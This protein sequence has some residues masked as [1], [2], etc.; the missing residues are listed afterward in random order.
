MGMPPRT[1]MVLRLANGWAVRLYQSSVTPDAPVGTIPLNDIYIAKNLKEVAN[2]IE[3][4]CPDIQADLT[5]PYYT[6]K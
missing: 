2:V 1:F 3:R 5:L 6:G 4:C